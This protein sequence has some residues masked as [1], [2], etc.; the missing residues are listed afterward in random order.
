[1]TRAH[2]TYREPHGWTSPVECLPSRE[3]AEFLR[4]ATNA[5]TPAAA[6]R[7]TWSITTCDDENCG[8]RR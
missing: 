3:A 2:L 7:R 8:A 6:E 1:M 5:L 4:D